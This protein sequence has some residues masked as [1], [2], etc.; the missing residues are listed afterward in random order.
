MKPALKLLTAVNGRGP[1][2]GNISSYPGSWPKVII[3][4]LRENNFMTGR[5]IEPFAGR[6]NLETLK[7]DI[8]KELEPDIIGTAQRLPFRDNSFDSAILDPPYNNMFAGSLYKIKM[9]DLK[10]CIKEAGRVVKPGGFVSVLCFKNM[11]SFKNMLPY[12][13]VFLNLGPDRHVRCL[14]VY[15][16]QK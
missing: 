6:S 7:I 1:V 3:H 2:Q 12:E 4:Y 8:K 5:I 15:L 11:P 16:I 13:R 10:L 9:P 14:N